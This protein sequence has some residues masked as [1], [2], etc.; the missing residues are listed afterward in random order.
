MNARQ[1][2]AFRAIARTGTVTAA[3]AALHISQPA[4]SRLLGHLEQQLDMALFQRAQGRL[5]L[6]PEGDALLT[7]VEQHFVGLET[8]RRAASRIAYHGVGQLRIL[9]FPSMTSGVLPGA[10]ARLLS[11]HPDTAIT[12]DTDT[13]DRVA[14]QVAAGRYDIGFT[15]GPIAPSAAI[16]AITLVKQPWTFICPPK[17]ALAMAQ[18]IDIETIA[19]QP[20]VTFS[21]A[22]SLR[23][24]TDQLFAQRQLRPRVVCQA[25]TIESICAL[26]ATGCGVAVIHP[27]ARHVAKLHGLHTRTVAGA[28]GLDL[29]AVL[30]AAPRKAQFVERFLEL[31]Q[32]AVEHDRGAKGASMST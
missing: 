5:H 6:T 9:G 7:E 20:L 1:I 18:P 4:V 13:T 29:T 14:N 21:P 30:M 27:F 3:A 26:V 15:A 8:L 23:S 25:Q 12:L 11:Q 17:H 32:R 19:Q 28:A 22:M 16:D 31:V 2:E 10:V 24:H